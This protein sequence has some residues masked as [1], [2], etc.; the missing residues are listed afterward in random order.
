MSE[1]LN[2]N[3]E[4]TFYLEAVEN[5]PGGYPIGNQTRIYLRNNHLQ[6]ALTWL[7]MALGMVGVFFFA[8]IRKV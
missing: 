2:L 6:Y 1:N 3:I 5:G 7:F 8:S 4:N